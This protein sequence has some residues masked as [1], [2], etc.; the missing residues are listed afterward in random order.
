VA[1]DRI[2]T[3]IRA[4]QIYANDDTGGLAGRYGE[5]LA[6]GLTVADVQAW[7]DVLQAVSAEDVMA[8]AQEVLDRR[9]AVTGHLE[10]AGEQEQ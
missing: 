7:P 2:K 9:T 1:L 8:A 3:Q 5:A 4:D 6:N 10:T